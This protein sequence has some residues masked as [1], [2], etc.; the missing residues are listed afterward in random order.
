MW[1]RREGVLVPPEM[2]G[3]LSILAERHS[4]REGCA[5]PGMDVLATDTGMSRWAL[6]RWLRAA[7]QLGA[8]T[9]RVGGGHGRGHTTEVRFA[10]AVRQAPNLNP[11]MRL[12]RVRR[13]ARR[14]AERGAQAHFR[15]SPYEAR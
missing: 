10:A 2:H 12:D 15:H 11:L 7:V 3:L 5:R 6:R 13:A 1:K 4:G 9:V 8:V 14:E